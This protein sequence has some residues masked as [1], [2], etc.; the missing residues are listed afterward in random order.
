MLTKDKIIHKIEQNTL[1]IKVFGVKKLTL[2]GSYAKDKAT[3]KSD[4]DFLVEFKAGR[5][6]FDDY[7]G[8]KRL[9]RKL[10]NKEIDLIKYSLIRKELR[11]SILRGKKIAAI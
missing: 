9:L 2:I 5:G 6:L 4:I 7:V 1:K 10:F 8:L 11:P 3:L